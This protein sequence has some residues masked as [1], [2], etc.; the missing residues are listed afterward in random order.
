MFRQTGPTLSGCMDDDVI[1]FSGLDFG[2]DFNLDLFFFVTEI[3]RDQGREE[4]E[5]EKRDV[6]TVRVRKVGRKDRLK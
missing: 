6:K 1:K 4:T 5:R 2:L 3:Y